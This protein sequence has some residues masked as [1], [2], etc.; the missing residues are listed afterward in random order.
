MSTDPAERGRTLT[1]IARAAIAREL[2]EAGPPLPTVV[3]GGWL[4][5]P[6]AAFVT[7]TQGGRLRGCIGSLEARRQLAEDVAANARAAAF[8]D[9]RFAPLRHDELAAT[10]VE[11]S[12]LSAAEPMQFRDEVDALRQLRPGV[13]GVILESGGHRATFLPQVWGQLPVPRDFLAQLKR[14]AGLAGDFW[15]PDLR[16]WRYTV[17]K[18]TEDA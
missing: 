14:K 10:Q 7:L 4:D 13:D 2:G 11:V 12:V 1:A 5:A 17:D 8:R 3:Q 9:P 15:S 18:Y 6:G 16:L